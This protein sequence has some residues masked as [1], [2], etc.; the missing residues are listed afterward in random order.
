MAHLLKKSAVS[1][2]GRNTKRSINESLPMFSESELKTKKEP[3]HRVDF[4][5]SLFAKDKKED[6]ESKQK[7]YFIF[8]W[9]TETSLGKQGSVVS[10]L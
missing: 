2:F 6:R 3:P 5:R 8:K 4:Y 10:I 9:D 7:T 1:L